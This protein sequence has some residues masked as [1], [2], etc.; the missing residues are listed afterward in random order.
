VNGESF[1]KDHEGKFACTAGFSTPE[2][3]DNYRANV[4]K[5]WRVEVYEASR[6][7]APLSEYVLLFSAPISPTQQ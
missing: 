6:Y 2:E 7:D 4:G 1:E 5:P 3:M